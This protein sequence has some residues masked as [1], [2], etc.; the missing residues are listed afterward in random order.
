MQIL[1]PAPDGVVVADLNDPAHRIFYVNRAF[2]RITGYSRAEAVGQNCRYL[3]GSDRLQPEIATL[4]AAVAQGAPANVTLRNYRKDG[5]LFWNELSLTLLNGDDGTPTHYVGVMRDVTAQKEAEAQL[6]WAANIDRLTGC[7]NAYALVDR[8]TELTASSPARMMVIKLDVAGFTDVNSAYGYEVGDALQKKIAARLES[9]GGDVVGLICA[10]EFAIGFLLTEDEDGSAR[11][12]AVR[13]RLRAPFLLPGAVIEVR[14]WLGYVVG[15]PGTCG[16]TLV[17]HAGAAL[18]ESKRSRLHHPCE[19]DARVSERAHNKRRLTAELQ[20]GLANGEFVYHYQPKVDLATG[21][22]T[23]AEALLRWNHGLFG[24]QTP[25]SFIG[26][27]EETG[28][29]MPIAIS[30]FPRFLAFV[31]G[32]NDGRSVPLTFSVNISTSGFMHGDLPGSLGR[33]LAEAGADPSWFTLELTEG[34]M[35]ESSPTLL[36]TFKELR[37]LGFGLSIDDFGTGYSSLRYLQTFPIT[38]IKIDRSFVSRLT[39]HPPKRIVVDAVVRLGEALAVGVIAE[40]IETEEEL[41]ALRGMGC[42]GGQGYL[43]GK[44]MPQEAFAALVGAA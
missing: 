36:A 21:A 14:F 41:A 33:Q 27:A 26:L 24:V 1:D 22:V 4:H 15:A 38:E 31:K 11:L 39:D 2:E 8:L 28:L 7:L 42:P 13:D 10:N 25:D 5:S 9:L 18:A 23:G 17:R 29:L 32:L 44:A 37:D 6:A 20:L 40:G 30:V 16:K 19:Y 12:A 35:A 3:Q 34:V 43:F